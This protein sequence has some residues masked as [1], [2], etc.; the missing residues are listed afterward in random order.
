MGMMM[1]TMGC[2]ELRWRGTKCE[3]GEKAKERDS[4]LRVSERSEKFIHKILVV[5]DVFSSC[6]CSSSSSTI[7][8]LLV[9]DF[10]SQQ[11]QQQHH[12]TPPPPCT[13]TTEHRPRRRRG[14][15]TIIIYII[16]VATVKRMFPSQCVYF[17]CGFTRHLYRCV[18]FLLILPLHHPKYV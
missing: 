3:R 14:R 16:I 11:Q 17:V 15:T 9:Q 12:T 6:C 8:M 2:C 7:F 18:R 10:N 1:V 13:S 4:K 5:V